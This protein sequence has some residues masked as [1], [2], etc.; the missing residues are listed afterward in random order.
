MYNVFLANELME[1]GNEYGLFGQNI[2]KEGY[3]LSGY[4]YNKTTLGKTY[5]IEHEESSVIGAIGLLTEEQV[6]LLDQW[7]DIPLLK[8]IAIHVTQNGKLTKVYIYVSNQ[9]SPQTDNFILEQVDIKKQIRLFAKKRKMNTMGNCDLH[10]IYPCSLDKIY[11]FLQNPAT[12]NPCAI[13]EN[14]YCVETSEELKEREISDYFISKLDCNSRYEFNDPFVTSVE[15]ISYGTFPCSFQYEGEEY[16]EYGFAYASIHTI[17]GIGTFSIVFPSIANPILL[18]MYSFCE[19]LLYIIE[20]KEKIEITKWLS[21]K[22]IEI[23]GHPKA[24]VFSYTELE[25]KEILKCL[26]YEMEPIG[27]ICGKTLNHWADDNIAQYDIA[28]VYASD[29]CLL[30]IRKDIELDVMLRLKSQAVELFF[31]EVLLFQEAAISRVCERVAYHLNYVFNH[32]NSKNSTEVL[33]NLSKEMANAIMF[34]DHKRL[35]YP[36]VRLSSQEI[37]QRFGLP[38]ELEKYYKYRS[39]LDEMITLNSNEQDEVEASLMNF[40]LLILTMIQVIPTIKA[41]IDI[42]MKKQASLSDVVSLV[43]SLSTCILLYMIY[44]IFRWRTM[45]S[46]YRNRKERKQTYGK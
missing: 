37:A 31:I 15:R 46:I 23:Y 18:Q 8:R 4:T 10:L 11:S 7:M 21:N 5:L 33:F 9:V 27:D 14:P 41:F 30:E 3:E 20:G 38:Q 16:I 6:W 36:S 32:S 24:I 12:E 43:V 44:R 26:A 1:K 2:P 34:I 22:S 39:I 40:L 35:R 25:K 13:I 42:I 17:T 29:R 19:S 28:K 45:K